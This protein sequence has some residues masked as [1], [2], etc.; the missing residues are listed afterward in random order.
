MTM[1]SRLT[2]IAQLLAFML[3]AGWAGQAFAADATGTWKWSTPGRNGGAAT[4][5]SLNLKQDGDKLSGGMVGRNGS[6]I[7][8]SD[9]TVKDDTISFKVTRGRAGQQSTQKFQGKI[10]G[11]TLK[12]TIESDRNGKT[13][14][15]AWEAKR[16]GGKSAINPVGNWTWSFQIPNSETKI[17]STLR[18]K[19]ADGKLSGTLAGRRGETPI[20]EAKLDG[21]NLSFS[22][23]RERNGQTFTAKYAGKIEGDT[24]KGKM[25]I[26]SG[27]QARSMDWEAKRA[28]AADAT[29]TWKWTMEFNGNSVERTIK[30]K[31]EGEKL[32]GVS[33]FNDTETP[34]EEG[35]VTGNEV[36]FQVTRE[37]NGDKFTVKYQ[38][39]LEGD[40]LK[41]KIKGAMGGQ[42]R[43]FDWDAKRAK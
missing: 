21:A 4:E 34:I 11:D 8:I 35:K 40:S 2:V 3:L 16:A 14:S 37:R 31:Q 9:A 28:K 19:L 24:I 7:A 22:I 29:G 33:V 20:T 27:D 1:K 38:G 13:R 26:G 5:Q 36:S 39:T 43:E 32:S 25:E 30:L 17:E 41:G 10:E 6:E 18:L 12:G 42:E 23:T 15:S